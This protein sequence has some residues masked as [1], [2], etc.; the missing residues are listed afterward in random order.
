MQLA[1]ENTRRRFEQWAEYQRKPAAIR[2]N[3]DNIDPM[4]NKIDADP[5]TEH[6]SPPFESKDDVATCARE[7]NV[8][9]FA[10][11]SICRSSPAKKE[12]PVEQVKKPSAPAPEK[13]KTT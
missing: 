12:E 3:V 10:T 6:C 2:T 8:N 7:A 5:P 4:V 13:N 11:P 9:D 1:H